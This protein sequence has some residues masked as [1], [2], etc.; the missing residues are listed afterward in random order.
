MLCSGHFTKVSVL[1]IWNVGRVRVG[2]SYFHTLFVLW[3]GTDFMQQRFRFDP[4][5]KEELAR[6]MSLSNGGRIQTMLNA[7]WLAF[8]LIRGQLRQLYPEV[9]DRELTLKL[10][11]EL[12]T[13]AKRRIPQF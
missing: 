11:E 9:D 4:I 3:I 7:R 5:N 2:L 12:A 1:L 6:W 13:R 10:F 8:G